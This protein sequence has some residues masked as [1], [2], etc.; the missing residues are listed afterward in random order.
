MTTTRPCLPGGLAEKRLLPDETM[1][2]DATAAS[3]YLDPVP[4]GIGIMM[5]E[6]NSFSEDMWHAIVGDFLTIAGEC[7]ITVGTEEETKL[8][9]NWGEDMQRVV[10]VQESPGRCVLRPLGLHC[11]S[12]R[13]IIEHFLALLKS[14]R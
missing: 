2:L 11:S 10:E 6:I 9:R 14:C 5:G 3:A 8:I 1:C 12:D 4:R 7:L 13:E